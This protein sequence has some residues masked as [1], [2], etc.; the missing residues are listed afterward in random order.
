MRTEACCDVEA[1][2][3]DPEIVSV[4]LSSM[5]EMG[6]EDTWRHR[7]IEPTSMCKS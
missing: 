3:D 6:D 4:H 5:L 2:K 7:Q 1:S